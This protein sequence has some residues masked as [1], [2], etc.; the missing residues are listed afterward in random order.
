MMEYKFTKK[1]TFPKNFY[2]CV[3]EHGTPSASFVIERMR[4]CIMDIT[5]ALTILD[6]YWTTNTKEYFKGKIV[7]EIGWRSIKVI[8]VDTAG[9]LDKQTTFAVF[10]F[11][12]DKNLLPSR[13][14]VPSSAWIR[15]SKGTSG[16]K[17][18]VY[19]QDNPSITMEYFTTPNLL[20]EI[21]PELSGNVMIK[22]IAT[23]APFNIQDWRK[24][25]KNILEVQSHLFGFPT[26]KFIQG[27]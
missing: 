21:N 23:H 10:Y 24:A 13:Q 16:L 25:A 26:R 12:N 3:K 14:L 17:N 9:P 1:E 6:E 7:L 2:R 15:L 27:I 22:N 8:R 19:T 18:S 11:N 20:C 5:P 4:K